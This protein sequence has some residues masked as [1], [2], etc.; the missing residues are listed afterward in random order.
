VQTLRSV[1]DTSVDHSAYWREVENWNISMSMRD[2]PLV[3][4]GLGGRYTEHMFND[5]IS[6]LYAEYREWPHNT[7]LGQLF[8]LGLFP[9]MAVWS[10]FGA[11]LFL[12]IRSY[13]F[14]RDA[15]ERTAALACAG[16]IVACHVLAYGDT[17]AHYAQY[18]ITVAL[19]IAMAGKLAV[20]TG[21]WA[22]GATSVAGT[23]LEPRTAVR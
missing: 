20:V 9:F 12:A 16:A 23:S 13:R 22:D 1:A 19:A 4:V 14:A 6:S 5:D 3:G 21:A 7:V 15:D 2:H 11:G 8:L 18:K 17:G 10:L